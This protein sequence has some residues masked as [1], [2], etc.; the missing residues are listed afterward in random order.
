[1]DVIQFFLQKVINEKT[2]HIQIL[3]N[4]SVLIQPLVQTKP[5][6]EWRYISSHY[7]TFYEYDDKSK[8]G[9]KKNNHKHAK[10]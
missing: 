8:K 5:I 4:K 9:L 1:M 2:D 6:S 3:I 10:A 7:Y